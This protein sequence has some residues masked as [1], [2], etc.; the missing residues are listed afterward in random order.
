MSRA[1]SAASSVDIRFVILAFPSNFIRKL[2][3]NKAPQPLSYQLTDLSLAYPMWRIAF[4]SD[5]LK[6]RLRWL[7]T[8]CFLALVYFTAPNCALQTTG[9]PCDKPGGCDGGTPPDCPPDKPDC[10]AP[11]EG[12]DCPPDPCDKP[13]CNMPPPPPA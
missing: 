12:P 4:M 3:G 5:S 6:T 10:N 9:L 8:G 7:G 2:D 1:N 13:D 11:C